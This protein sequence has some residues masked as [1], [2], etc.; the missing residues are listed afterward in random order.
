LRPAAVFLSKTLTKGVIIVM[1]LKTP[2]SGMMKKNLYEN[3]S[4]YLKPFDEVKFVI[5]SRED[6]EWSRDIIE[7]YDIVNRCRVFFST[8]V[9]INLLRVS[10][11]NGYCRIN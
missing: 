3:L 6:Y 10:L 8:V 9:L 2:S 11:Q 1:D 4:D 5:G 7:K